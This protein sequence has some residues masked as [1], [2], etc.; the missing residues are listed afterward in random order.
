MGYLVQKGERS[1]SPCYNQGI[2]RARQHGIGQAV[3]WSGSGHFENCYLGLNEMISNKVKSQCSI[4]R[5]MEKDLV[6]TPHKILMPSINIGLDTETDDVQSFYYIENFF[7]TAKVLG[8]L[9]IHGLSFLAKLREKGMSYCAM[10][11]AAAKIQYP[12]ADE[13]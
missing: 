12:E 2:S 4:P 13:D 7:Y 6:C 10:D 3:T 5:A 9:D 8:I 11:R 1:T